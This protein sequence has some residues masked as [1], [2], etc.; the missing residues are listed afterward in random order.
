V[1]RLLAAV[2][3][4]A[5]LHALPGLLAAVVALVR[6]PS[7]AVALAAIVAAGAVLA[8]AVWS[9]RAD[10]P[11]WEPPELWSGRFA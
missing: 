6:A 9:Y 2:L 11:M 5:C 3:A 1:T 4:V 10:P 8:F 7:A